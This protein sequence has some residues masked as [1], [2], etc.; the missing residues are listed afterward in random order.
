MEYQQKKR[1]IKKLIQFNEEMD[2]LKEL[3]ESS[4][5]ATRE[6]WQKMHAVVRVQRDH[7]KDLLKRERYETNRRAKATN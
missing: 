3:A 5:G 2:T 7:I 6:F 1:A 4:D